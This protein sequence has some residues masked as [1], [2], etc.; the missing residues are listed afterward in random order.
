MNDRTMLNSEQG[1]EDIR[2]EDHVKVEASVGRAPR[3][4]NSIATAVRPWLVRLKT[5][6]RPAGPTALHGLT[7][8]AIE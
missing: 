7:A 6:S 4:R 2:E 5:K 1:G 8:V 3:A